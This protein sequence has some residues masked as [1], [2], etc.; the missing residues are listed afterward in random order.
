VATPP[1]EPLL[2][3]LDLSLR[4]LDSFESGPPDRGVSELARE[5]RVSKPTIYRVLATLQRHGY[6]IQNPT[7]EM[8]SLGPRLRRLGQVAASRFDLPTEAR[9]HMIQLRNLTQDTVHLAVLEGKEAV[10]VAKEEGL[11]P[12]Q[13]VSH[14]GA[15]CP[16]H[17]VATGKVL[18][19]FAS[20]AMQS[21]IIGE[22]LQAYTDLTYSTPDAIR[23]ELQ[24]IREQGYGFNRGEWRIEVRGVAAPV[25]D[26]SGEVVAAIGVCCPAPRMTDTRVTEIAAV[27]MNSASQLSVH[28]GARADNHVTTALDRPAAL[29]VVGTD[30]QAGKET[31]EEGNSNAWPL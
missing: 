29:A 19:A 12:V 18:L 22:G 9:P 1:D 8:Y 15:H 14:V 6:L 23:Q 26:A 5:F 13:V 20:E 17:C 3:S 28:I 31:E 4:I 27:V 25:R 24:R 16:A 11:L 10:Y 30:P 21:K 2:K 7:S